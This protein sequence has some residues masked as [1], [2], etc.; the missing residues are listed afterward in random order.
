MKKHILKKII[1][2]YPSFERGGVENIL[3]NL[4]SFFLKQKIE[5]VLITSNIKKGLFKNKLFDCKYIKFAPF[6]FLPNR[7][8]KALSAS[9]ILKNELKKSEKENTLVFS[10]QGS[11]LAII[12]SKF[13]G[14]KIVVRNGEDVLGSTIYSENKIQALIVL[15]LKVLLYNFADKIIT[16]SKGSGNSL[17]KILIKKNKIYPI[18][19][20]Y[21]KKIYRNSVKS[22]SEY[23]LSIGRL[24]KEKDFYNLIIAFNFI[25]KKIPNYKLIIIGD[26]KSKNEL[27]DLVSNLGLNKRIIFIG[28]KL[29]LKKYYINSKLFI[30]N[31]L[32]EGLGN[33]VID[34]V[35]YNLPIITTNCNSREITDYGKGGFLVPIKNP[36]LLS[37]KILFCLNNYKVSIKKSKHAKKRIKR[38]DCETNCNNYFKLISKTINE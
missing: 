14:F 15:L 27:Q 12:I 6:S 24:V 21:L 33:V 4:I 38:F 37:K 1:I 11:S 26:G 36:R 10:L 28:W 5:I 25:K 2:F 22:R 18:Y 35:N 31:S 32:Y 20:P 23:L 8:N 19:N 3:V 7:I 13:L 17:R 34:A 30:L 9:K 16:N 29:K